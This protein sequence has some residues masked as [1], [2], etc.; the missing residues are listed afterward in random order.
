MK[1]SGIIDAR[2]NNWALFELVDYFGIER[3]LNHFENIM[4]VVDGWEPRSNNY[5]IVKGFGQQSSL[6]LTGGVQPGDHAIQGMMY[7]R[8]KKSK[9]Q[10]SMFRLTGH[11]LVYTKDGRGRSKKEEHYLSLTNNDVYTPFQ[12]LRGSPTRYVFGLKSEMPM[13]M[14]EK[15][16]EDYVKWFAVQTLDGLREWLQV[17]RLAKNQI[18][19]RTV[20]ERRVAETNA[21]R[22]HDKNNVSFKPLMDLVHIDHHADAE[23][24]GNF[25]TDVLSSINKIASATKYDPSALVQAVEASGVDVSEF[26]ALGSKGGVHNQDDND[27]AQVPDITFEPGSLLSKP[28]KMNPDGN[29]AGKSDSDNM[30]IKGSLLAQPRESKAMAASRAMQSVMAQDGD[31]FTHGSLLRITEQTKPRPAHFGGAPNMANSSM[32]PLV[33]MEPQA[34]P[35]FGDRFR[36]T[37]TQLHHAALEAQAGYQPA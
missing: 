29:S 36:A 31:V 12:P 21:I 32:F 7:Y 22:D 35:A 25:T 5:I 18:K 23:K 2:K 16:D 34:E 17:L 11:N 24:G 6:T 3:P 14:F 19:F 10:K 9:W 26:K 1:R 20:L 33:Q 37:S 8:I 28:R 27:E 15:P 4:N 30:F 13:Q